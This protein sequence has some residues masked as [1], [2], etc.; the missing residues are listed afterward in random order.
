MS[1][2][3]Y[4]L[5]LFILRGEEEDIDLLSDLLKLK[6][7]RMVDVKH[8]SC[9]WLLIKTLF[10]WWDVKLN[11]CWV[12]IKIC[13]RFSSLHF[14]TLFTALTIKRFVLYTTQKIWSINYAH[15]VVLVVVWFFPRQR[16]FC[17]LAKLLRFF[18]FKNGKNVARLRVT[19]EYGKNSHNIA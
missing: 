4:K 7:K 9:C 3:I 19:D 13:R 10:V 14:V 18:V 12:A 15:V 5:F 2:I 17:W 6:E 16:Y 11:N 8:I 1:F